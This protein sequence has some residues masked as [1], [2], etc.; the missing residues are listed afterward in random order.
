[1]PLR[2]NRSKRTLRGGRRKSKSR[3]ITSKTKGGSKITYCCSSKDATDIRKNCERSYTSRCLFKNQH[4]F[5]CSTNNDCEYISPDKKATV[6][7]ELPNKNKI[8][9]NKKKA[10]RTEGYAIIESRSKAEEAA[11]TA[12]AGESQ[13]KMI[14][15]ITKKHGYNP[16]KDP[17][18]YLQKEPP[19]RLRR[20]SSGHG[21]KEPDSDSDSY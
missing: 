2:K 15:S 20:T 4:K 1:M 16:A 7:Q 18:S 8:A 13:S 11:A 6:G 12:A 19:R 17:Y 3:R 14:N 21:Y 5:R 9:I 10:S